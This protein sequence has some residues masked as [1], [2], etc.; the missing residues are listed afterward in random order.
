MLRSKLDPAPATN[1][2]QLPAQGSCAIGKRS[3][4]GA[5]HDSLS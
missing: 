3:T 5:D 1:K 2:C 4:V